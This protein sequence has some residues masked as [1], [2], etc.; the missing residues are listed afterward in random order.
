MARQLLRDDVPALELAVIDFVAAGFKLR[1][2][3]PAALLDRQ[4]PILNPMGHE[5][6]RPSLASSGRHEGGEKAMMWRNSCPLVM[7][8]DS[9]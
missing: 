8:R 2:Q 6:A 3:P 1:H 5:D 9:A 4:H 7:P